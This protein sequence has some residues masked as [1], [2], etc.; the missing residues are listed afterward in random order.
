MGKGLQGMDYSLRLW[1]V[2][3]GERGSIGIKKQLRV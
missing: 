1:L 3:S 2:A